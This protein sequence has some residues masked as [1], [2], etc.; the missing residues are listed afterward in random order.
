MNK[1]KD[2]LT[3]LPVY[4][5]E[6]Y[7]LCCLLG[8]RAYRLYPDLVEMKNSTETNQRFDFPSTCDLHENRFLRYRVIS[9]QNGTIVTSMNT[10][11]SEQ[12]CQRYYA[13]RRNGVPC[14]FYVAGEKMTDSYETES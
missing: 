5:G 8:D 10:H 9:V 6:S 12:A 7:H 4:E 14:A 11:D 13:L 1:S 3:G 2:P